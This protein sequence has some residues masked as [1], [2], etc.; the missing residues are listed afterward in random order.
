MNHSDLDNSE[1]LE[2]VATY[3]IE[4]PDENYSPEEHGEELRRTLALNRIGDLAGDC[5]R[6]LPSSL[7]SSFLEG[8]LTQAEPREVAESLLRSIPFAKEVGAAGD[9]V[10][11]LRTRCHI[12]PTE[13]LERLISLFPAATSEAEQDRLASAVR[14]LVGSEVS[15]ISQS[16]IALTTEGGG[17]LAELLA[18]PGIL[19]RPRRVLEMC[20]AAFK[21]G[22]GGPD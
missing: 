22:T 10:S 11:L 16:P 4:P 17:R 7:A 2:L 8:F 21:E 20:L 9:V 1:I 13:I 14:Y 12:E 15:R 6:Q 3:D 5:V 18:K 19:E